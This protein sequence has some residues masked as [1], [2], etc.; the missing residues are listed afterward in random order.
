MIDHRKIAENVGNCI[1][2][3]VLRDMQ[4]PG[5]GCS[6]ILTVLYHHLFSW[7]GCVKRQFLV[8]ICKQNRKLYALI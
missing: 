5:P 3:K 4:V 6:I 2:P 1:E 8:E 7:L